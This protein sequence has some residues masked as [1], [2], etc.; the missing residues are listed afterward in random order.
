MLVLNRKYE[1]R[2]IGKLGR[3]LAREAFFGDDVLRQSTVCGDKKRGLLKLDPVKMSLLL[4][5]L[6]RHPSFCTLL[7]E[8]FNDLVQNKV[9]P[10]ISHICKELRKK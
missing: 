10:S 6:H 4:G 3:L 1:Q 8:E 9:V 5:T 2:D 7:Q